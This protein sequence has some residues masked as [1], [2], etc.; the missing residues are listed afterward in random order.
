MTFLKGVFNIKNQRLL[1][2]IQEC[3]SKELKN[4]KNKTIDEIFK[5]CETKCLKN[6]H[7]ED[8]DILDIFTTEHDI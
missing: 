2:C 6:Q 8:E 3:V 5:D 1:D 4:N 7:D